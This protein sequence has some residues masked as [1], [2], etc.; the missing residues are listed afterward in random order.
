MKRNVHVI[1]PQAQFKLLQGHDDLTEYRVRPPA[2]S[3][4]VRSQL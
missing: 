4:V 2:S 1:V 3:S